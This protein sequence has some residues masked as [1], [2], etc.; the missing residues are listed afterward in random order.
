MSQIEQNFRLFIAERPEIE[1]CYQ[2][3]LIN[4][5]SLARYL[6]DT[7][8]AKKSQLEAVIAM[9]RRFPFQ[10]KRLTKKSLLA[11]MRMGVKDHILILDFEKDKELLQKLQNLISHINYDKGDTFKVVVGSSCI[12]VFI[13]EKKE[14][15]LKTFFDR[16]VLNNRYVGISELS[17]IF[18]SDYSNQK[19]IVASIT[20]ELALHDISLVEMLTATPELLIYVKDIDAIKSYEILKRFQNKK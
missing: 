20:T 14:K 16:F 15:E 5:R 1:K 4:R 11:D 6:I 7:G 13:D 10:Q 12:K 19:G 2:E 9:L 3:G 17:L 8:I 18:S